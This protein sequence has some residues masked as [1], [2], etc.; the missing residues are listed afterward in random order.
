MS[1]TNHRGGLAKLLVFGF[2]LLVAAAFAAWQG[3]KDY[4]RFTTTELSIGPQELVLLVE[5]GDSFE[6]VLGR[7]RKIGI[8]EGHDYYWK[9]LAWQTDVVRRLRVGEY[10]IGH[11]MTPRR[12]LDKLERGLVI[13]HSF[14]IVE[15]WNFRDL[16]V[17]LAKEEGLTQTI[18]GL[19]HAEVMAALGKPDQH[20]EGRFLPETY[21]FTRGAKDIDLLRRANTALEKTLAEEWAKRDPE[22]PLKSPEEALILASIVEKETGQASERHRIAGVFARR[23]KLGMK[24][25]TDPTVIYGIGEAF[26]GNITRV[27]LQTDTPYNT[28]TRFGFPPTPIAMPGRAAI[29]AALHPAPGKDLYFVARGNGFHAFAATLEEHNR[30]VARYQLRRGAANRNNA[31]P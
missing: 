9:A 10:A 29:E 19:S 18:A 25:Q 2:L 23:I 15:G 20:P 21:H 11:G 3:W 17:A 6:R 24:L 16:R 14:T 22:V 1:K 12:L 13:Q 4:E 30:N 26:D 31:A 28:Y 8:V 27:H 5:P 7:L